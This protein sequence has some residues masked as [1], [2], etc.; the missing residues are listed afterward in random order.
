[1]FNTWPGLLLC[2]QNSQMGF[3][4]SLI[5]G[6]SIHLQWAGYLLVTLV[7]WTLNINVLLYK[8]VQI[9]WLLRLGT[10]KQQK[11]EWTPN[12]QRTL[13][14]ES[15]LAKLPGGVQSSLG[16]RDLSRPLKLTAL[17]TVNSSFEPYCKWNHSAKHHHCL[18]PLSNIKGLQKTGMTS[19]HTSI[20]ELWV[21]YPCPY[22][23]RD[24]H[25][26]LVYHPSVVVRRCHKRHQNYHKGL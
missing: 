4:S 1:M 18:Y 9:S 5:A 3:S 17:P 20:P 23:H 7:H 6:R 10:T 14:Q 11:M 16:T 21:L 15:C 24:P 22:Y 25:F 19:G 12:C 8:F 2:L 13:L 26:A